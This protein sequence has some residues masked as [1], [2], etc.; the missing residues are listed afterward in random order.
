MKSKKSRVKRIKNKREPVFKA[1]GSMTMGGM[2]IQQMTESGIFL[3]RGNVYTK[4][5]KKAPTDGEQAVKEQE[6]LRRMDA[7]YS[8][9]ACIEGNNASFEDSRPIYMKFEISAENM[10]KAQEQFE[11]LEKETADMKLQPLPLGQ[12]L[13]QGFGSIGQILYEKDRAADYTLFHEEEWSPYAVLEDQKGVGGILKT[14]KGCFMF[15]SLY[16]YPDIRDSL[17]EG[18]LYDAFG[19]LPGTVWMQTSVEPVTDF[20]VC[21]FI[22]ERYIGYEGVLLKMKRDNPV[23]YDV[24]ANP[25]EADKRNFITA[26]CLFMLYAP[27]EDKLKEFAEGFKTAAESRKC[28]AQEICGI[29]RDLIHDYFFLTA[30]RRKAARLLPAARA[31][32]LL[33]FSDISGDSPAAEEADMEEMKRLFFS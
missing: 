1:P 8:Y 2:D 26:D 14:E 19:G 31:R 29:K 27:D 30:G 33:P 5:Y 17:P 4:I 7:S 32:L 6:T 16:E 20:S 10:E 23:L 22:K 21:E 3:H 12:R 13:S 24:L 28:K 18:T 9:L 11:I 15:L 25:A